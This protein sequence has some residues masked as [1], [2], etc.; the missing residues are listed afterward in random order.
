LMKLKIFVGIQGRKAEFISQPSRMT[1][2]LSCHTI[3]SAVTK[4][5]DSGCLNTYC[6][7][8]R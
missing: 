8:S 6:C 2:N 1:T 7:L 3:A 5:P 4:V